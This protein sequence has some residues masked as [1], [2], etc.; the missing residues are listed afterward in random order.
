MEIAKG[1]ILNVFKNEIEGKN[2]K[3]AI[4]NTSISKKI[5]DQYVNR[6]LKVKFTKSKFESE[7]AEWKVGDG[8][9]VKVN[10]AFISW[11]EFAT[12]LGVKT[13]FYIQINDAEFVDK[14]GKQ[15]NKSSLPH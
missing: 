9:K 15:S 6:S 8:Y 5:D 13:E 10:E 14:L 1:S 2:G 4:L 11:E 3:F 7:L 12:P